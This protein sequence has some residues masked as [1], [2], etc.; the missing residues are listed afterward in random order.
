MSTSRDL[1]TYLVNYSIHQGRPLLRE[2]PGDPPTGV[3]PEDQ[4]PL[5]AAAAEVDPAAGAPGMPPGG[6]PAPP[7]GPEGAA[8]SPDGAPSMEEPVASAPDG[9]SDTPE[10]DAAAPA[11]AE[12]IL[13][14]LVKIQAERTEKMAKELEELS[15][16]STAL[17]AELDSTRNGMGALAAAQGEV[18]QQLSTLLPKSPEELE[19]FQIKTAGGTPLDDYWANYAAR[20]GG[21][22]KPD[23]EKEISRAEA[24][25]SHGQQIP[26]TA[27][28]QPV[29]IDLRSVPA[30][31]SDQIMRSL[32]LS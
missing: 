5:A 16:Q 22:R 19:R 4:D 32:H 21:L 15:Q 24:A 17:R 7:A 11:D 8:P 26:K 27:D 9:P 6:P 14:Q 12:T 1:F 29:V 25:T 31:S 10:P 23:G 18:K 20:N 3:N 2:A 30:L 13:R 28:P